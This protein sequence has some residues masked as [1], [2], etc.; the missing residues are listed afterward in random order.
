MRVFVSGLF[1]L[2]TLLSHTNVFAAGC[3]VST[4]S[5]NLG[6]LSSFTV[7]ST[8]NT[9]TISSGFSCTG[10]VVTLLGDNLINATLGSS[11]NT[12]GSVSRLYSASTGQYLPYSICKEAACTSLLS[13]T[14]TVQWYSRTLLGLL[15]L[16][17]AANGTM[18]LYIRPYTG[19]HLPRGIYTDTIPIYWS[20][21]LCSLGV[22]VCAYE[23]GNDT[24]NITLTLEVL[25]DC[26]I[27]SAPDLSFSSAAIVSAFQPV[28]QNIKV[29]CTP[30]VTY[31]VAF[32]M[33]NNAAGGWRRMLSGT[34]ALQYNLYIPNTSTVWNTVNTVTGAGSGAVQSVPYRAEI[35]A[36][37]NNVPAGVYTDNVR[38]IV[39]Y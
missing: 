4:G 21:Q 30:E 5:G 16:F 13:P 10:G 32:D 22:I 19:I 26:F 33:G 29:R 7:A 1:V 25:N 17:T 20:W 9:T 35:N 14:T 2:F 39:S 12:L 27:D 23:S 15:G 24:S 37:Q 18:P 31:R 34:N 36:A 8:P 11:S 3:T 28:T 6:S 38:V